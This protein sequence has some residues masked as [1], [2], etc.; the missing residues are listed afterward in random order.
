MNSS[1]LRFISVIYI[2]IHSFLPLCGQIININSQFSIDTFSL[3]EVDR[4]Y[5]SGSDITNLDGLSQ[6]QIVRENLQII[7]NPLL[8]SVTIPNLE[9]V[10]GGVYININKELEIINFP[11]LERIGVDY[12]AGD[13][14]SLP[15]NERTRESLYIGANDKLQNIDGFPK[16]EFVSN[17][18]DISS[19]GIQTLSGFPNLKNIPNSIVIVLNPNLTSIGG[20]DSLEFIG[21]GRLGIGSQENLTSI[22]GFKRLQGVGGRFEIFNLE[23]LTVLNGFDNL[24]S[25]ARFIISEN[26]NLLEISGFGKLERVDNFEITRNE[27]LLKLENFGS[28]KTVNRNFI[29]NRNNNLQTISTFTNLSLVRGNIGIQNNPQLSTC[30]G[31]FVLLNTP[32]SVRGNTFI[33]DNA[34]GCNFETDII[35]ESCGGE[36]KTWYRDNDGDSF[37]NPNVQD[38]AINQP[39]GFVSDNTDCNDSDPTIFPNAPELG[40]RKDNDCNG[41]VDDGFVTW[42][43]DGDGDGFGD[44]DSFQYIQIQPENYVANANDCDD[45]NAA[46]NPSAIEIA[47]NGIDENCDG[48]DSFSISF[49][50]C[51]LFQ[52]DS[53]ALSFVDNGNDLTFTYELLNRNSSENLFDGPFPALWVDFNQN[54]QVD[55]LIDRKY[56]FNP[57]IIFVGNTNLC[58]SYFIT[59]TSSTIC[60]GF[61]SN[62]TGDTVFTGTVLS[63]IPHENYI[64]KIPKSELSANLSNANLILFL[65][66]ELI[67]P[68]E[69]VADF[70]SLSTTYFLDY[71]CNKTE[72]QNCTLPTQTF[73]TQ[74]QLDNFACNCPNNDLT[75]EGDLIINGEDITDLSN[76]SCIKTITGSVQIGDSLSVPS[77]DLLQSLNGLGGI[78]T[79]GED[80]VVCNNPVLTNLDGLSSLMEVGGD[81]QVKNCAVIEYIR[82]VSLTSVGGSCIYG[83]LPRLLYIG[84]NTFG[85]EG[86]TGFT[87][88][89]GG[90]IYQNLP[91]LIWITGFGG[92]SEIRGDLFFINVPKLESLIAYKSIIRLLGCLHLIETNQIANFSG[93]D[94]LQLIGEDIRIINNA[95]IT[96]LSQLVSLVTINGSLIITGNNNLTNIAGLAQLQSIGDTLMVTGNNQL[97]ACCVLNDLLGNVGSSVIIADNSEGCSSIDQIFENCTDADNDGFVVKDD[98]DDNS[99]AVNPDATEI[100]CNGIDED[101]DGFDLEADCPNRIDVDGDGFTVEEGDCNDSLATINPL[102]LELPYNDID[103]NCDG[104]IYEGPICLF[105]DPLTD[106]AA[107]AEIVANPFDCYID[108]RQGELNGFPIFIITNENICEIDSFAVATELDYFVL[109]CAGNRICTAGLVPSGNCIG[110]ISDEGTIIYEFNPPCICTAEFAPV[111]ANGVTYSNACEAECAGI[112]DYKEGSCTLG[113]LDKDGFTTEQG[114]CDDTD[115]DINPNATEIPCN[116]I[117]ENC[118]GIDDTT[119]CNE[120]ECDVQISVN[121]NSI[122]ATGFGNVRQ[123]FHVYNR[124]FSNPIDT[125][126]QYWNDCQGDQIV[127]DLLPGTYA[128]QVQTFSRDWS[129]IICDFTQYV[130]IK[131]NDSGQLNCDAINIEQTGTT[132]KINNFLTLNTI[133]DLFD[134]DF[135]TVSRCVGN[136]GT[137]QLIEDLKPGRHTL[138]VKSYDESWNFICEVEEVFMVFETTIISPIDTII[139][140][141]PREDLSS[142]SFIVYPNPAKEFVELGLKNYI[143]SEVNVK[144]YN[145]LGATVYQQQFKDLQRTNLRVDIRDFS[146]GLHIVSIQCQGVRRHRKFIRVR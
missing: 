129:E 32:N 11:K 121:G 93:L 92:L 136:C 107:L 105:D 88:F 21:S 29:I 68:E 134:K 146:Y 99:A 9:R 58:T 20:F 81:I 74:T 144:I 6:L 110:S 43:Y 125:T 3:T 25:T 78:M 12:Q 61:V 86:G 117:D 102:A 89:G 131:G 73:T 135:A 101:C 119:G 46:I 140:Q 35:N 112:T 56:S 65:G 17:N 83:N 84:S 13:N 36:S 77:N 116:G 39:I 91:E 123:K 126:C 133:V 18:I 142:S 71:D 47:D 22:T 28:L 70:R 33:N 44:L 143:D 64:L 45:E 15:L 5:I 109:D 19:N 26:P 130:E 63:N 37:G 137:E 67:F 38:I 30:C 115:S 1:F 27:L 55:S 75:I 16:L 104:E 96:D 97:T 53:F 100:A 40:D 42:Y 98:C 23:N 51:I 72:S 90:V 145:A 2:T 94:S 66:F 114:D 8:K 76:L 132:L 120:E 62:A 41:I 113:D 139:T 118:D 52:N 80:L 82:F 57:D 59:E 141:S 69:A 31:L 103:E 7:N 50:N 85:V 127:S 48:R 79:I 108:I 128:V 54:G 4:L 49:E 111:C 124:D 122:S 24:I 10:L 138:R 87:F 14:L 95:A 34:S 60:G 106:I